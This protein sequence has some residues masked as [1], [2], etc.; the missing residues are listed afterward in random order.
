MELTK[1]ARDKLLDELPE[2]WRDHFPRTPEQAKEWKP[3]VHRAALHYQVLCVATTRIEG[4]WSAYCAPV[5]GANHDNE[6]DEVLRL[7]SKLR[8][9]VARVM[10]QRFKGVPYAD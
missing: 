1:T 10:F 8:E 3:I 2:I 7:G 4:M 9:D 6:M 5:P